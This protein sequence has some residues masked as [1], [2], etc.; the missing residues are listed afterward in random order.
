MKRLVLAAIAALTVLVAPNTAKADVLDLGDYLWNANHFG[1]FKYD[2]ETKTLTIT[3]QL[4]GPVLPSS[5][6]VEHIVWKGTPSRVGIPGYTGNLTTLDVSEVDFSNCTEIFFWKCSNLE[7]IT[8]LDYE[9]LSTI[10]EIHLGDTSISKTPFPYKPGITYAFDVAGMKKRPFKW[11]YRPEDKA[12][13]LADVGR[14]GFDGE[15]CVWSPLVTNENPLYDAVELKK[16]MF[17]FPESIK[18]SEF[19]SGNFDINTKVSLKS[20]YNFI[21]TIGVSLSDAHDLDGNEIGYVVELW[22]ESDGGV[23]SYGYINE[24]MIPYVDD[25]VEEEPSNDVPPADLFE[26][27]EVEDEEEAA[28]EEDY[29]ALEALEMNTTF[30][31][32]KY[33]Y[34]VTKSSETKGEVAFVKGKN[35]KTIT[36]PAAV[37][38]DGVKYKVTSIAS[39][40]LQNN[41]KVTKVTIG[42]NVKTIGNKAFYGCKSLKTVTMGANVQTIGTQ[43]FQN[44]TKLTKITVP[45]KVKTIGKQAFYGCKS[46]KTVTVKSTKLTSVGS[47][48]FKNCNKKLTVKVTKAK[49][50]KYKKALTKAGVKTIKK[51]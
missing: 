17:N 15:Q 4:S 16:D 34:K 2:T 25:T 8:G 9:D 47:K 26:D 35:A 12:A 36:I 30:T 24:V 50:A 7:T 14:I 37:T 3:D 5:W 22:I 46:L 40:A 11:Y 49:Y 44:C 1:D 28:D 39:K 45:A 29:E 42:K 10:T 48:A 13:L 38:V 51:F 23:T 41:T 6:D 32:N 33:T 18:A 19:K 43:A 27:E 21:Y 31:V 20:E